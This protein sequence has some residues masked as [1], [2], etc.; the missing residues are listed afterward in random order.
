MSGGPG[1]SSEPRGRVERDWTIVTVGFVLLGIGLALVPWSGFLYIVAGTFLVL[2][3]LA[4]VVIG[5]FLFAR[6]F[7][8][9]THRRQDGAI[10]MAGGLALTLAAWVSYLAQFTSYTTRNIVI[11]VG[12]ILL[13]AGY[14]SFRSGYS[15]AV[16]ASGSLGLNTYLAG[17]LIS[18][19]AFLGYGWGGFRDP[20]AAGGHDA[21]RTRVLDHGPRSRVAQAGISRCRAGAIRPEIDPFR[22]LGPEVPRGRNPSVVAGPALASGARVATVRPV[23]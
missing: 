7:W 15:Q 9:T 20:L 13:I 17:L 16:G 14:L 10:L 2:P 6:D 21:H 23:T 8:A 12:L 22:I 1:T 5:W 11:V 4:I 18:V 19:A 3:G